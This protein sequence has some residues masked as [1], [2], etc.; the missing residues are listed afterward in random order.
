[1]EIALTNGEPNLSDGSI[2]ALNR[3][4]SLSQK[5]YTGDRRIALTL[6]SLG[7]YYLWSG[8]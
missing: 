5:F 6:A 2:D 1:M 7:R 3:A 4:L 8:K